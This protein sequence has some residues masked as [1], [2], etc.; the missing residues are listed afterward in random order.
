MLGVPGYKLPTIEDVIQLTITLG[1]RTNSAIRC[2]G[3]SYNTSAMDDAEA[4]EFLSSESTRLGMPAADP[5]R[6]GPAFDAL[7]DKCLS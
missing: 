3:V 7:V 1:S 4:T 2:G 6:G 5:M